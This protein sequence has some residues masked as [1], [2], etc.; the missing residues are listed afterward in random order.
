LARKKVEQTSTEPITKEE[1]YNVL[2]FAEQLY[3]GQYRG[4]YTPQLMNMRMQDINMS[5][6]VAT[7]DKINAALSNPKENEQALIGY[8]EWMELNSILFRRI[9]GYFQ[10]LLAWDW[11]YYC[12][13]IANP[14]EYNSRDYKNDLAIL[15]NFTYKFDIKQEF[16]TCMKE[17]IRAEAYFGVLRE[18]EEKT[19]IQELPQQFCKITGRF[20]SGLL[21]D[22]D[23]QWFLIPSVSLDLYP[24]VFKKMYND[25]FYDFRGIESYNP[26]M[27]VATRD[28]SYVYWH[29]TS[30]DDGFV[31]FKFSP[32]L[33]SRVPIFSSL[34]PN[35]ILE[36]VIRSLQ[37]NSYIQ[38]ASKI[39]FSEVPLLKE[40]Q[41]KLKDQIAVSS[42]TLGDRKSVV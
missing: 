33:A 4:I 28:G 39:I 22:F 24:D 18:D 2:A 8:T 5:P 17:I 19:T 26:A 23:L 30:P 12:T 31:V 6:Q 34:M 37:T 15:E 32:E 7:A 40:T 1:V 9:M 41:A 16:R 27:D 25:V 3:N 14:K 29:Q 21:F 13:N 42:E 20:T 11:V 36:P 38:Q 10:G 35:A